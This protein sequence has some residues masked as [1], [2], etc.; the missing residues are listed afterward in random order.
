[1]TSVLVNTYSHST[2]YVADNIL[3]SL[4]DIIR[5]SG[6][7][8]DKLV[9]SWEVLQRGLKAWLECRHLTRVN[10]EIY[11]PTTGGLLTRWDLEVAYGWSGSDGSFWTD[12]DQLR[13]HILKQ[14]VLPSQAKYDVILS[15]SAGAPTVA[16]WGDATLRSTAGMVRQSLGSTV[17]HGGLEAS[18]S[19]WRKA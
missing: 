17:Q 3:K 4:K 12:T 6:L 8:P 2:T 5:L 13:Y 15:V 16:G 19:Y 9:S 18:A 7:D 1:M 10:L 14:G 11:N